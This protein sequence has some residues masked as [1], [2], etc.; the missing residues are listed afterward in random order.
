[1]RAIALNASWPL[2]KRSFT[3][4]TLTLRLLAVLSNA[5]M[6]EMIS[7]FVLFVRVETTHSATFTGGM[8]GSQLTVSSHAPSQL[9]CG[10]LPLFSGYA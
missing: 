10:F 8:V 3:V 5:L 9:L 7:F 4:N 6:D 1:M 2:F